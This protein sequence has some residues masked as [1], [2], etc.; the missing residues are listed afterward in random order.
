M[1]RREK[2]KEILDNLE[3]HP[4]L[5]GYKFLITAVN[6]Y[7]DNGM[8]LKC[9]YVTIARLYDTT[10]S[11]VERNLRTTFEKNEELIKQY[12]NVNYKISTGKLL[13]LIAREI[14]ESEKV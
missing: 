3:I 12:F 13:S 14:D 4:Y 7:M 10:V 6:L 8:R 9:I 1:N 5:L 2:L 11:R